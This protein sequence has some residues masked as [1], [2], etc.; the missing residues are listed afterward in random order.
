MDSCVALSIGSVVYVLFVLLKLW[1]L[2]YT[3][4]LKA[5]SCTCAVDWRLTFIQF[6]IVFSIIGGVLSYY[7]PILSVLVLPVSIAF[8]LVGIMYIYDMKKTKC[9]CSQA[10]ERD[11][12]EI[13]LYI[14][15]G[16]W[17]V[18]LIAFAVTGASGSL[19]LGRLMKNGNALN[20]ENLKLAGKTATKMVS[21]RK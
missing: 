9:E 2:K 14:S 8:I 5:K 10:T 3:V 19:L 15:A 20:Y 17:V 13:I 6:A 4:D 12:L 16:I 21:P 1:I 7:V 18:G 11:A